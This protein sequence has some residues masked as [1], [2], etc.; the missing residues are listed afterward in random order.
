MWFL[1]CAYWSHHLIGLVLGVQVQE[2]VLHLTHTCS[3]ALEEDT[4]NEFERFLS[5]T[6]VRPALYISM[7][8]CLIFAFFLSLISAVD[9]RI[10][11][12]V[13]EISTDFASPSLA[14]RSNGC[15]NIN[16]LG[17]STPGMIGFTSGFP[18]RFYIAS[19]DIPC[20][21]LDL[22]QWARWWLPSSLIP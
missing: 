2:T 13:P 1:G 12:M 22:L 4:L 6:Q 7:A 21:T 3:P 10:A 9:P 15:S 18:L 8:N 16:P 11:L 5:S 19:I 17:G 20:P 14:Q